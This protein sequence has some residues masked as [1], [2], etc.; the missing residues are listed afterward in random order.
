[1]S[2]VQPG[3]AGLNHLCLC[4]RDLDEALAFYDRVMP[5]MG[6]QPRRA[7]ESRAYVAGN[8]ELYLQQSRQ[9]QAGFQRYG[10][11]LQHLACN[12]PSRAAVDDLH[13]LLLAMGADITDAP[14]EY[15]Q[16]SAGYYAVFF[17]DPSGI[18]LEF[19]YTPNMIL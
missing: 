4:V 14:A 3:I 8:Y 11:G 1:M 19:C 9:P 7:P 5:A 18:A 12:A 16:Y 15:P 2:V 10:I 13:A 6:W 17:R